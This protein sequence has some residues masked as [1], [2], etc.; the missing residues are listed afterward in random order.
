MTNMEIGVLDPVIKVIW[1]ALGDSCQWYI[2]KDPHLVFHDGYFDTFRQKFIELYGSIMKKYMK[3]GVFELD[4]HK[5]ASIAI[6]TSIEA[7][8]ISCKNEKAD[9]GIVFL[10]QEMISTEVALTWMLRGL[11]AKLKESGQSAV[12]DRYLMPTAFAC[13]TPYFEVFCRNLYFARINYQLNPLDIAEK[14]F[15]LEYITLLDKG[16]NLELLQFD[17]TV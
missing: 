9:S 16:I 5:V 7:E 17:K 12:I 11:N 6:I 10:G 8:V 4:R 1:N 2:S 3:P 14:L 15:L 13:P